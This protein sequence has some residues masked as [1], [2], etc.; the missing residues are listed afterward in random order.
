MSVNKRS[1]LIASLLLGLL[2]VLAYWPL[3]RHSFIGLDDNV[4]LS[5]NLHVKPGLTWEGVGWAF[6]SGHASNWHPLTWLSHMLDCQLYSLNPGWHHLTNLLFHAINAALLFLLL[7]RLTGAFWRS[8]FV[9][10]LFAW[11]PTHVESVAWAAERKDVLSTFFFLLSL[12]AYVRYANELGHRRSNVQSQDQLEK[13][14]AHSEIKNRKS[15]IQNSPAF[16]YWLALLLFA[17]GLMSKP[18]LV[19]L[20]FVLL[21][22]DFWPLRRLSLPSLHHSATPSLRLILEKLPFFALSVAASLVTYFV[23]KAGGAVSSLT[24]LPLDARFANSLVAYIRYLSN[25]V[26]PASLSVFYPLPDHWPLLTVVASG[27]VFNGSVPA[28][29]TSETG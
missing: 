10:G 28:M 20:P 13:S 7:S 2:T 6:T 23:Q 11:H 4:Y 21:L 24:T 14:N 8:A 9:A 25:T 18:M 26:W 3:T 5:E 19:T 1:N 15:K 29:V 22:L 27:F 16:Y 17:L 12:W